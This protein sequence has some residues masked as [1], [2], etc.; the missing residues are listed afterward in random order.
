M[1]WNRSQHYLV[2]TESQFIMLQYC[3]LT[4]V[5]GVQI[6][7]KLGW[8]DVG[9]AENELVRVSLNFYRKLTIQA[10][11]LGVRGVY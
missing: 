3:D 6:L 7:Y 11:L 10:F 2:H 9:M 5:K 4:S 8:L 1:N